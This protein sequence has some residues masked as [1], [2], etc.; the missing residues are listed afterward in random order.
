MLANHFL[1]MPWNEL[2]LMTSPRSFCR[3]QVPLD[4]V[5]STNLHFP[6]SVTVGNR[7]RPG[8]WGYTKTLYPKLPLLYIKCHSHVQSES[9]LT[10]YNFTTYHFILQKFHAHESSFISFNC[11]A[12]LSKH[13]LFFS[14]F[15]TRTHKV[16]HFK[17]WYGCNY[18]NTCWKSIFQ[19]AL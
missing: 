8:Q 11:G 4:F 3:F 7:E 1:R 13:G 14:K 9:L 15:F 5:T 2:L 16:E 10:W 6:K 19:Y 12:D 18:W 17:V